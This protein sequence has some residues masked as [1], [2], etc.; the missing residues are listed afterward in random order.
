MFHLAAYVDAALDNVANGD[1]PALNDDV[2]SINNTH[3]VL[4]SPMDLVAAAAMS[5]TITRSK[6]ASPSMRQVASPYIRPVIAAVVPGNNP[7]I[8]L[9]YNTPYRIPANE[10]IQ[11]QATSGVA[12]TEVFTALI[13]LSTGVVPWPVGNITPLSGVM[14]PTGH[15]TT[16]VDSQIS[17]VNTSV[18]ATPLVACTWISSFAGIRYG[19]LYDSIMFGLLPG[20][21]AAITGRM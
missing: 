9:S 3:F 6:V 7:N 2:L 13:W 17:A 19:V 5:A 14:F 21:T 4:S 1:I 12:M 10:E 15:G 8:M 11:V 16:P 20:T 18:M